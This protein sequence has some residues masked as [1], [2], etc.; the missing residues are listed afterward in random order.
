MSES[1]TGDDVLEHETQEI[2]EHASDVGEERLD[3]TTLETLITAVI[4][5]GEVSI[6]GL[7]AMTIVGALLTAVPGLNLYAAVAAG[8]VAFPIGFLLVILGRS[9]LFTENFL[10]P[11]AAVVKRER[12]VASLLLLWLISWVGNLVGCLGTT[13]LL[14]VPDAIGDPIRP[15]LHGVHRG[16]ARDRAGWRFRLGDPGRRG[17]DR[18]D[19]GI[20]VGRTPRRAYSGDLCQRLCAVRGQHGA[21][22][23]ERLGADG[24][25]RRRAAHAARSFG[26][27]AG[28]DGR[29]S[30]GG[31]AL[32]TLFRMAQAR[33]EAKESLVE[34]FDPVTRQGLAI[35]NLFGLELVDLGCAVRAGDGLAGR[36]AGPLSEPGQTIPRSRRR[37]TAIA[38]WRSPGPRCRR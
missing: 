14:L 32:V 27:D 24:G 5:G 38:R 6:G 1:H 12:S 15:G 22:D 7:A 20:A 18:D 35:S 28:G 11:V 9:E 13:A 26:L 31:P 3:R 17:H 21:L 19:M 34:S 33:E 10:I 30:G 16:Q 2:T 29:Q 23:R 8:A 37:R 4:G 25:H 36:R